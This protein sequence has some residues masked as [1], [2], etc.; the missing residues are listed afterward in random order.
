M[1][2]VTIELVPG[3]IGEPRHMGTAIISNEGARSVRTRGNLGDY[4][5][6]FSQWGKP[7]K[8]WKRGRVLGFRRKTR[9]PW[10]LLYLALR[11][12]VGD[13]NPG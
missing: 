6:T 3:G 12:A 2:R 11:D 10:D 5:A 9:G 7:N 8:T 4:S 13:R 1:I